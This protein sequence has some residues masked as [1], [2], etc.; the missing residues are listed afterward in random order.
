TR[1]H[2]R[3]HTLRGDH[4]AARAR[5]LGGRGDAGVCALALLR[6]ARRAGRFRARGDG[7]LLLRHAAR[8]GVDGAAAGGAPLA[9]R[10]LYAHRH[11]DPRGLPRPL[12][13]GPEGEAVAL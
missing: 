4:D 7:E 9:L 1:P 3:L 8:P 5:E 2:T 6:L 13:P 12:L 11:L 10:P